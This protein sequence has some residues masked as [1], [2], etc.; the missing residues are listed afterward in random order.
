[1]GK[2]S[3]TGLVAG[4]RFHWNSKLCNNIPIPLSETRTTGFVSTLQLYLRKQPLN[5]TD[6]LHNST[7]QHTHTL[8]LSVHCH[9]G[10]VGLHQG[11]SKIGDQIL[12]IIP[13]WSLIQY[14]CTAKP[15]LLLNHLLHIPHCTAPC[16]SCIGFWCSA[17]HL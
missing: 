11:G 2:S 10:H 6:A 8:V 1:M 15:P 12:L 7:A 13:C 4:G 17:K 14:L 9:S 5:D 3:K 16:W